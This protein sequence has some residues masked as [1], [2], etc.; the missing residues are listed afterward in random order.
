MSVAM[1]EQ[2]EE[3][4]APPSAEP[5]SSAAAV[6]SELGSSASDSAPLR[7]GRHYARVARSDGGPDTRTPS[8]QILIS[9]APNF[10]RCSPRPAINYSPD[11]DQSVTIERNLSSDSVRSELNRRNPDRP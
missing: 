6:H 11:R 3:A 1:S 9:E 2:I 4:I 10:P 5:H 7:A 8:G